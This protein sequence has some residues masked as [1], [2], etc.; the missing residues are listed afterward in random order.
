MKENTNL[1]LDEHQQLIKDARMPI[2]RT[3]YGI[4]RPLKNL[5]FTHSFCVCVSLTTGRV[6][7]C[8]M[9]LLKCVLHASVFP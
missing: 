8:F 4:I 9:R 2:I 6:V 1:V 7:V 3:A 5:F